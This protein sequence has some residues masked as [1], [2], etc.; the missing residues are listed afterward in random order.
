MRRQHTPITDAVG[1][2]PEGLPAGGLDEGGDVE[3]FEAVVAER[4]RG[5]TSRDH[6]AA[7]GQ[8]GDRLRPGIPAW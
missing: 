2:I 8:R 3:P 1:E 5:E 6:L 4:Q 7:P